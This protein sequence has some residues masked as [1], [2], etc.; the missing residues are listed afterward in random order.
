MLGLALQF[1]TA[2]RSCIYLPF[3]NGLI[4]L[5]YFGLFFKVTDIT[6]AWI[7]NSSGEIWTGFDVNTILPT[8]DRA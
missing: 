4:D 5:S 1:T 3:R 2:I 8:S 6:L 7:C